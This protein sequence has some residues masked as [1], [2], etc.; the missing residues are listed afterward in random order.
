MPLISLNGH[1]FRCHLATTPHDH[2]LGLTKYASLEPDEGLLFLFDRVANRTFH[3]S[4]V[5]Y[6]IDIV[7]LDTQNRVTKVVR[8]AM[9]GSMERWTFP[10]VA[11]VLELP[12]GSSYRAKVTVGDVVK[13]S[14]TAGAA[15]IDPSQVYLA[16]RFIAPF[17]FSGVDEA[18]KVSFDLFSSEGDRLGEIQ[19]ARD[20]ELTSRGQ[21][22]FR[23]VWSFARQGYGPRLYEI[24]LDWLKKYCN[25]W[26]RPDPKLVSHEAEG[27]WRKMVPRE[28]I[29]SEL[30][31]IPPTPWVWHDLH[32]EQKRENPHFSLQQRYQPAKEI[33]TLKQLEEQGRVTV[34][35]WRTA[36]PKEIEESQ[37]MS[38][39]MEDD[40]VSHSIWRDEPSEKYHEQLFGP[41]L[42]KELHSD[43]PVIRSGSRKAQIV[44]EQKFVDKVADHL[45]SRADKIDW[46]PDVLNG[47]ATE[48]AVVNREM[49][50]RWLDDDTQDA[51]D[52]IIRAAS[53]QQ[54][55][56]LIGDAF[57][58]AGIATIARVGFQSRQPLLVLYREN[59]AL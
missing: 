40:Q 47:G 34:K 12:G 7:G 14:K 9:P 36:F 5:S 3:M 38:H 19:V 10:R 31:T 25:A 23:V 2:Y 27:V 52:Y 24:A 48:R 53:T 6:P 4:E 51:K 37:N 57:L 49:L 32:P 50:V 26:L 15:E 8:G 41:D 1:T 58:L 44:D 16:I 13:I 39:E 46:Q 56:Q 45:I 22:Q 43:T 17:S 33:G 35:N 18:I 21:V 11:A 42:S 55:L 20:L 59:Q 30:L 54:G 29:S 28:D